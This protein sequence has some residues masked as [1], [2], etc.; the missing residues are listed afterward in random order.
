MGGTMRL[1]TRFLRSRVALAGV[2]MVLIGG[3]SGTL[4]AMAP[5][6]GAHAT[7]GSQTLAPAGSAAAGGTT[8]TATA[9]LSDPASHTSNGT[10]GHPTAT[11]RPQPF[12]LQGVIVRVDTVSGS[13]ALRTA[14]GTTQKIVVNAGTRYSG[15]ATNL[16]GVRTGMLAELQG[17]VLADGTYV[18]TQLDT[19]PL[20]APG[21]GQTPTPV[22]DN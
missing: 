3:V 22:P 10:Q 2:G 6:L 1:F 21:S 15:A 5:S 20:A 11:S 17:N 18:A 4:A 7:A 16:R 14:D 12:G 9:T 13:L 19:Q 8:A